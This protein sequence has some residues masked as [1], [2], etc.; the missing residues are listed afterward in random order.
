ML[1]GGEEGLVLEEEGGE[2]EASVWE[3]GG[4][5]GGSTATILHGKQAT[6]LNESGTKNFRAKRERQASALGEEYQAH[7]LPDVIDKQQWRPIRHVRS[8]E[9]MSWT[10]AHGNTTTY[11]YQYNK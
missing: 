5:V 9:E 10:T 2:E 8:R 3:K 11:F 6:T 4:R 7:S 1:G